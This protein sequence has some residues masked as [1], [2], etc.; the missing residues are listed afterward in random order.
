MQTLTD[1]QIVNAIQARIDGRFDDPDLLLVGALHDRMGDIVEIL[2]MR[3]D[4]NAPTCPHCQQKHRG[5]P[6]PPQTDNSMLIKELFGLAEYVE[7]ADF[8]Y[9]I[10]RKVAKNLATKLLRIRERIIR[11]AT[12]IVAKQCT[13]GHTWDGPNRDENC[14]KCNPEEPVAQNELPMSTEE[15]ER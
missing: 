4:L 3:R 12:F 5:Y 11:I 14:P 13:C 6:C 10:N 2:S 7:A 1:T 9:G 15:R 8:K